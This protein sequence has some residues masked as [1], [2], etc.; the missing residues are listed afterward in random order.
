MV[1]V[2]IRLRQS[3]RSSE[4]VSKRMREDSLGSLSVPRCFEYAKPLSPQR[5]SKGQK[6]LWCKPSTGQAQELVRGEIGVVR[7]YRKR[8]GDR[9]K[10]KIG[11]RQRVVKLVQLKSKR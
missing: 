11:G 10:S 3:G 6:E 7:S 5:S 4:E 8:G 1:T 9:R 2:L